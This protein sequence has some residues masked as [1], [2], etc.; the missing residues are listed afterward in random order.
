MRPAL[1][2]YYMG[3]YIHTCPKMSYKGSYSPSFLLC[4]E[5]LTWVPLEL[6]RPV[7]DA[8]KYARL[9]D[10]LES[11]QQGLAEGSKAAR[12]S[13]AQRSSFSGS[14]SPLSCLSPDRRDAR[15]RTRKGEAGSAGS[16]GGTGGGDGSGADG[17]MDMVA[18]APRRAAAARA[19]RAATDEASGINEVPLKLGH[20]ASPVNLTALTPES[21]TFVRDVL[22]T[23]VAT[24]GPDLAKRVV[25][26]LH[27]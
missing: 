22:R 27:D 25:L 20:P 3:F 7:L 23:Y 19:M 24:I 16:D 14:C 1:K 5:R 12:G 13:P 10:L 11:P 4:P 6:C 18:T 15:Q 21:Q 17:V 26:K 9:S 2:D 8:Q